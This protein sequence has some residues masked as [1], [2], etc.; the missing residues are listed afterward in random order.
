MNK[1]TNTIVLLLDGK[2]HLFC[3]GGVNYGKAAAGARYYRHKG[4]LYLIHEIKKSHTNCERRGG[5]YVDVRYVCIKTDLGAEWIERINLLIDMGHLPELD[6]WPLESS[7]D[8][9]YS[10][11]TIKIA[12]KVVHQM[13]K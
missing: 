6:V 13:V 4:N 3:I 9:V 1:G 10:K 5:E 2:K 8:Y 12:S 7:P 11:G